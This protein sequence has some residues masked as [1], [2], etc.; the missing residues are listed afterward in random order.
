M[1]VEKCLAHAKPVIKKKA[2]TCI[3]LIFMVT[4]NFVD[5]SDVLNSLAKHKNVKVSDSLI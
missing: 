5:C 4:E 2:S 1:L 3:N